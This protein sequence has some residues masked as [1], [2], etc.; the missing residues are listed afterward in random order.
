M[1]LIMGHEIVFVGRSNVGKS[2]LLRQL[3]GKNVRIGRRPGVTLKPNHFYLDDL[4]ITDMPGF[5]FMIGISRQGQ[6]QIK[7]IIVQY[8]DENADRILV[9]V[10]VI[11]ASSFIEIT[12]RWERR[13]EIPIDVELFHFLHDLDIP[14][15]LAVN[16]I[17]KLED[18]DS[19]VD[20]IIERL[21]MLPPWRQWRDRVVLMCAKK[22]QMGELRFLIKERLHAV[23]RDDLLKYFS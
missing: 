13:G 11:D 20:Q 4:L 22:G 6:E 14:V 8:L 19:E 18:I 23:K 21:D 16:K 9:A 10:Q 3:I 2:T 1:A 15:I 7:D 5:G 17:D 12:D